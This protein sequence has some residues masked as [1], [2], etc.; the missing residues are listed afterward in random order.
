MVYTPVYQ[1]LCKTSPPPAL[2]R[3]KVVKDNGFN[4][5]WNASFKFKS[6][7]PGLAILRF[8]VMDD[9]TLSDDFIGQYSLPLESLAPGQCVCVRACVC[10]CVH[11]Y[12]LVG[13][14]IVYSVHMYLSHMSSS[15]ATLAVWF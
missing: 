2:H 11:A 5:Q 4:P 15:L 8:V 9:D 6:I 13:R 10:A 12:G 1:V 14:C 7:F 3:T